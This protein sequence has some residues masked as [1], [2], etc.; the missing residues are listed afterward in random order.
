[1]KSKLNR[2]LNKSKNDSFS[3]PLGPSI[4]LHSTKSK[5]S[6]PS[7]LS[8]I[9]ESPFLKAPLSAKKVFNQILIFLNLGTSVNQE[10][11]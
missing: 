7:L 6:T 1:M 9:I 10:T 3:S 5:N 2:S 8:P 4:R 11:N